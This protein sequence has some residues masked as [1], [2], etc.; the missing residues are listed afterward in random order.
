MGGSLGVRRTLLTSLALAVAVLCVGANP[1][2]AQ[3][4]SPSPSDACN[5]EWGGVVEATPA[6]CNV[7]ATVSVSDP[8]AGN[9]VLGLG[10]AVFFLAAL[11]VMRFARG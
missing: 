9:I 8:V 10:L 7:P 2:H 6:P 5:W 1:V 4:P 3:T 11:T